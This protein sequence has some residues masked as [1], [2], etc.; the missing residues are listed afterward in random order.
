MINATT[1]ALR[2]L[3]RGLQQRYL[4]QVC[5]ALDAMQ[6][7][8]AILGALS[9]VVAAWSVLVTGVSLRGVG[10]LLPSLLIGLY[11]LVVVIRGRHEGI[12]VKTIIWAPLYIAWRCFSFV[13]AW[14]FLDRIDLGRRRKGAFGGVDRTHPHSVSIETASQPHGKDGSGAG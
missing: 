2:L 9:L 8:V 7:P 6:P 10:S 1:H 4:L 13:L 12:R 3:L 5:A 14:A 11:G